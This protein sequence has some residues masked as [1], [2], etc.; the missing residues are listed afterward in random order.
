[1]NLQ[2]LS[3]SFNY[4][5]IHFYS[6][7]QTSHEENR[8]NFTLYQGK[9]MTYDPQPEIQDVNAIAEKYEDTDN[10]NWLATPMWLYQRSKISD[11]DTRPISQDRFYI[12]DYILP[13]KIPAYPTSCSDMATATDYAVQTSCQNFFLNN[14]ENQRPAADIEEITS[15]A[16][17]STITNYF[18]A[19]ESDRYP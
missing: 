4:V 7:S 14:A 17:I 15:Y 13:H 9:E 19:D 12:D 3:R 2:T 11:Y 18:A 5:L 16:T 1:M 8:N 10:V 6:F